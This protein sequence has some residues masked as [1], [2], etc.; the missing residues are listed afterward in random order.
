MNNAFA[1]LLLIFTLLFVQ[2][3]GLMHEV[4]HIVVH[5]S[6]DHSLSHE[7]H[8]NL[9]AAYAQLGSPLGG[10]TPEFKPVISRMALTDAAPFAAST[11]STFTAFAA[12]AP[13]LSA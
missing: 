2:T 12:R 5:P 6:H 13:P 3:G 8:C 7:K 10:H 9:C 4:S 1:R 11:F